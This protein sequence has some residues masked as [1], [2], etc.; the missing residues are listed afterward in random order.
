MYSILLQLILPFIFSSFAVILIMFIAEKHGTKIGGII[1]T[2]PTTIIIAFIF[3]ALNKGVDFASHSV[4]VV[5]AEMGINLF[6]LLF[7]AVLAYRSAAFALIVS[8]IIWTMLSSILYVLNMMDVFVSLFVFISSLIITFL[9]LEKVVKIASVGSVKVHYTARKILFR[10]LLTGVII[11]TSVLLSNIG[12]V[13]SGIFSV[14]P[15][16]LS[17]T[18]VISLHEHGPNFSA[19]MAKSMIFVRLSGFD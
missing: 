15:A 17:S 5:P 9:L 11:S 12:E 13:I 7:F 19:G 3:I 2:L 4:A 18:M 8:F 10:G 16:I 6:F 14:F 1:G